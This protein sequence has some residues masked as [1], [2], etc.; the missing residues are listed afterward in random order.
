[1]SVS[2]NVAADAHAVLTNSG[3]VRPDARIFDFRLV[4]SLAVTG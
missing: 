1:M 4:M 3:T 2:R